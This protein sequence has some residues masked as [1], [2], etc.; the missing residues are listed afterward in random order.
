MVLVVQQVLLVLVVQVL[1]NNNDNY[2]MYNI[3]III[4][5]C[6]HCDPGDF[7]GPLACGGCVFPVPGGKLIYHKDK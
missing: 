7:P 1:P 3:L 4:L 5:T 2:N 6:K